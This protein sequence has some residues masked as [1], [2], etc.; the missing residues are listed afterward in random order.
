[1]RSNPQVWA[2]YSK[3]NPMSQSP[4]LASVLKVWAKIQSCNSK[5]YRWSRKLM[6]QMANPKQFG[7]TEAQKQTNI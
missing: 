3:E 7:Q 1:M 2:S 5:I 6:Q 4:F